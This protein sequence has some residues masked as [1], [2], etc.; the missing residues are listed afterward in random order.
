MEIFGVPVYLN[1]LSI[2]TLVPGTL[3][4]AGAFSISL[5]KDKS[6]N[7]WMFLF[8]CLSAG[9]FQSAYGYAISVDHPIGVYHRWVTVFTVFAGTYT[10]FRFMMTY[11]EVIY[12]KGAKKFEKILIYCIPITLAAFIFFSLTAKKVFRRSGQFWD[13]E[14]TSLSA[15]IGLLIIITSIVA[16][17]YSAR[18]YMLMKNRRNAMTYLIILV[19]FAGYNIPS[20]IVNTLWRNGIVGADIHLWMMPI[21]LTIAFFIMFVLFLSH[22]NERSTLIG[23][24]LGITLVSILVLSPFLA[25]PLIEDR[26]ASF[27]EIWAAKL[28]VATAAAADKR[29]VLLAGS[30]NNS[31]YFRDSADYYAK[32]LT[33]IPADGV[34]LRADAQSGVYTFPVSFP[35]GT[36]IA[37]IELT[38]L[39]KYIYPTAAKLVLAQFIVILVIISLFPVFFRGILLSPMRRLLDG[40]I[41]IS[42][43]RYGHRIENFRSDELGVISRHFDKMAITI[44]ASTTKLEETV[45]QRTAQ[46]TEE[47]KKSDTLLLNILPERIA[48]ELKEKGHTQPMRIESATVLFTDFVG[49]T[50]ISENLSPEE[51]VAELDKCFSYF[52]QVTEKYGLEKLKTIGDSFMCAGGV[53]EANRTHAIDACLAALEIQAFMNQMKEIKHQQGFPYWELRLGINTGPLVA[54][55][56]GHKK[57]AYD[58]W[59]DTVNTASRMESSGL[60]GEIN[61]SHSTYDLVQKWF[62]CEHRGRVSAKNKGEI[63]MY[64]LKCIRAEYCIDAD[65]RVPSERMKREYVSVRIGKLL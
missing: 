27:R 10:Y 54:G 30:Q 33:T 3:G 26:K 42:R 48:D 21:T 65:G 57:F 1:L 43:G 20:A 6:A 64:L 38:E 52:D 41:A 39:R 4:I 63:D 32:S 18:K 2:T 59:G 61:I 58:V 51:V 24:I 31:T 22:T 15:A 60:A 34:I 19:S 37:G 62:V 7:S 17:A 29:V 9:L 50:K 53:P 12:P 45:A 14:V 35:D 25:Y 46:L 5:I 44:E 28:Q 55:V 8:M 47:K 49:F 16:L 23:N 40:V 56:V 36:R 13:F 11:S